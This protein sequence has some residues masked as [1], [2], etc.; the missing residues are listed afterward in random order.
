MVQKLKPGKKNSFKTHG[1]QYGERKKRNPI[2]TH[3]YQCGEKEEKK[4]LRRKLKARVTSLGS[5]NLR[6]DQKSQGRVGRSNEGGDQRV[7]KA[8]IVGSMSMVRM[9]IK[10]RSPIHTYQNMNLQV[11]KEYTKQ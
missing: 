11:I 3:G 1:C 5:G 6:E 8:Q 10:G 9:E 4:A 7:L 2:E